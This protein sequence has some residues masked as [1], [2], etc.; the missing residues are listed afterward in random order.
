MRFKLCLAALA[1]TV[2]VATP[3]AAQQ[4]SAT[5]NATAKGVVLLPLTLTKSSD[6]DFGTVV[7]SSTAGTVAINA[8][9]GTRSVTGGVTGVPSFPGGR[10]LFQGAGSASQ[11]VVLTLNAASILTS[12]GNTIT[13]SSM[14]FDT[15]AASSTNLAGNLTTTRTINGTGAFAVGVGGTFAIAANQPNGVYSGTFSVTA[16]YQ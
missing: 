16:D 10:A 6:L 2:A 12:G 14:T 5:A 9:S 3:A 15:G 4:A 1:A 13:V 8:D 7:A 11:Q